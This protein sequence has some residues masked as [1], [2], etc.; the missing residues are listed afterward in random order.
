[1]NPMRKKL[2]LVLILAITLSTISATQYVRADVGFSYEIVHPSDADI[3]YIGSDNAP[4]GLRVLRADSSNSS[5]SLEFGKWSRNV[6]KTYTAAFGIVNEESFPV[7]VNDVSVVM[8]DGSPDYMQIWLHAHEDMDANSEAVGNAVFMW[9]RGIDPNN[10]TWTLGPGNQDSSDASF[11]LTPWDSASQVRYATGTNSFGAIPGVS[12]FVWVQISLV[13]PS[14]AQINQ[15]RGTITFSFES[16]NIVFYDAL[17]EIEPAA[18]Y[19]LGSTGLSTHT[20]SMGANRYIAAGTFFAPRFTVL[21]W[22]QNSL[23][24]VDHVTIPGAVRAIDSWGTED[25]RYIA[26]GH[27]GSPFFTLLS[28]DGTSFS[29]VATYTL[30]PGQGY[31]GDSWAIHSWDEGTDRCIAL[32]HGGSP[33]LTLIKWD[34]SSL[35]FVDSY[36]LPSA[37]TPLPSWELGSAYAID[38]WIEAGNR[39]LAVGHAVLPFLTL[40]QWDGSDLSLLYNQSILPGELYSIASW[41]YGGNRRLA[42]AHSV[43][44]RFTIMEWD[45]VSMIT[46]SSYDLPGTAWSIASWDNNYDRLFFVGHD[47]YPR[48]TVLKTDDDGDTLIKIDDHIPPLIPST[49]R[50]VSSWSEGIDQMVAI[51]HLNSPFFTLVRVNTTLEEIP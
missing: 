4:D 35:S 22:D 8:H 45:G 13:V 17:Y 51:A 47:Q 26:V 18:S 24:L 37:F 36:T 40:L 50:G 28:F 9:D 2:T 3:R 14:D 46:V 30:P 25:F 23:S 19:P 6:T 33:F 31:T 12:D 5:V 32:G 41:E 42:L 39:I 38:S 49:A 7:I 15:I 44:P 27:G 10:D 34:G 29:T 16:T 11:G 48:F 20:W 1:M 43:S 21:Q